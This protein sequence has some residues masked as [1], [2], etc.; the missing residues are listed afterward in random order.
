MRPVTKAREELGPNS[1]AITLGIF[2]GGGGGGTGV[3]H[4][5]ANVITFE[6]FAP[7]LSY[8]PSLTAVV[9]VGVPQ[10]IPS[11]VAVVNLTQFPKSRFGEAD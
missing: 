7:R 9:I 11:A 1:T 4:K 5:H 8:P 6:M 3:K 10:T 2:G